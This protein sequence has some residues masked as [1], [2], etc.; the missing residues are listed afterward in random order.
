[1]RNRRVD[2]SLFVSPS[3]R[4]HSNLDEAVRQTNYL[5]I[6]CW[7]NEP[8]ETLGNI[9]ILSGGAS[10]KCMPQ[11]ETKV[12]R[13]RAYCIFTR[14]VYTVSAQIFILAAVAT[15]LAHELHETVRH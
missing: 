13:L 6:Y 15:V 14:R 11:S 8:R 4:K 2:F 5:L 3:S 1:M 9:G 7:L 12:G 10:W